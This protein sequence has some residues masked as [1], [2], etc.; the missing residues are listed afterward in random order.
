MAASGAKGRKPAGKVAGGRRRSASELKPAEIDEL[1]RRLAVERALDVV[2]LIGQHLCDAHDQVGQP[3]TGGPVIAD[4]NRALVEVR[5][6]DR[7][8]HRTLRAEARVIAC[9]LNQDEVVH[10]LDRFAF[11]VAA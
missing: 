3:F 2:R 7:R 4:A 6:K 5:M 9:E 11:G 8:E 1:F 10:P